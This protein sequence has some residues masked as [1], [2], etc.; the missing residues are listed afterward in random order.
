MPSTAP[1]PLAPDKGRDVRRM[2]A[3]IA[4]RYDLLNRLLSAGQD[5]RWRR[6]VVAALPP[7]RPGDRVLDLCSGTGDLAL[8][9]GSA[10][11]AGVSVHASDF[12][13]PM[14]A[15]LPA[16]AA[17][18]GLS[19]V[20]AAADAL[21]LPYAAGS[22][23]AVTVAFGLRNV[24]DPPAALGEMGRVLQPGGRALVLEF[25][26]PDG[27]LFAA[28]YRAYFFRVLPRVGRL[29]SGSEVDA[30]RY[31]PDS[32]WAFPRPGELAAAF[33][34]HGFEVLSQEPLLGGAVV[35]HV[36]RKRAP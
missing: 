12:C 35:L 26:R 21:A 36:A 6:R 28:L 1:D 5:Q 20:L 29:L 16:K 34:R 22:F 23:R 18:R 27:R 9:I 30:Y 13:E 8:A 24:Q 7:L 10:A 3:S 31:L 17:Q 4:P 11:P 25:G 14:L 19:P 15:R 2:F 33:V 32:V